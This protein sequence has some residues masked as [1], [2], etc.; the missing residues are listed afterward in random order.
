MIVSRLLKVGRNYIEQIKMFTPNIRLIF[1]ASILSG[2][3]TGIFGV[4]FNLY[5]LSLGIKADGLGQILSAGPFAHI[6]AAIPIGFL[7]EIIGYKKAF[8]GIY[9]FVGLSQLAQVTV[10]DAT[11]IAIAAFVGGLAL[12]G[13]FVVRLPFLS[14]NAEGP[15]RIHIFGLDSLISYVTMSI[16]ALLGGYIPNLFSGFVSSDP[17]RYRYT[18]F[19]A[20]GL[21]LL[22]M[23][24]ILFIKDKKITHARKISL[25]PYLWGMDRFTLQLAVVELFLGLMYGVI[26]PFM[27]L[28]FIYH[29]GVSRETFALIE[30]FSLIPIII[31]TTL[32]PVI[33][34]KFG[35]VKTI[36]STRMLIPLCIGA[37]AF[38]IQP[39]IGTGSYWGYKVLSNLAQPLWFAFA[40]AAAT[41]KAKVA[42]SAWLEITFN[43]GMGLA[44]LMTGGFLV[45]NNY[46]SPF[47]LSAGAGLIG[48]VL[49]A[50]FVGSMNHIKLNENS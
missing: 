49:I 43:L 2:I 35:A 38:T 26:S 13:N 42:V 45:Q 41:P 31:G 18:L 21:T 24:P 6:F 30:A 46:T 8:L 40:M 34:N 20:G 7:G 28:Y 44:A 47:L 37:M 22:G 16:G 10:P 39:L 19:I 11:V 17:M 48:A 27:N 5:I 36:I 12:T 33:S 29:T 9:F 32:A 3:S 14:S 15:E 23:L 50:I 4:V 1:M 25:A